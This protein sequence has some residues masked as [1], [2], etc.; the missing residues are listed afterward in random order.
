MSHTATLWGWYKLDNLDQR[1]KIIAEYVWIDGTD[2]TVRS[3]QRTLPKKIESLADLPEWNYDG[4]STWQAVT[5]N[6]EVVLKPVAYYPDPFRKGDNVLVMC[7]TFAV[8]RLKN[9]IT[10]AN[11]N[12]RHF[13]NQIMEE[14]R[15]FEPWF[16][17]EQEYTLFEVGKA[18]FKWP[19]GWPEG[20]YPGPQGPYYCSAGATTCFG[21]P[22]MDAHYNA[23][24]YAGLKIAGTNGEVMPGQWEY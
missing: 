16:G 2:H 15:D 6:S 22:V 18:F 13:S 5:G 14:A 20:G 11:T 8:D 7:E 9:T 17:I 23:C 19:L 3:K 4:S 10:P 21:R 1:G 24:L 12:F